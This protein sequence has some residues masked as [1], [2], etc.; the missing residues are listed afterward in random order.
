MKSIK[1]ILIYVLLFN[2]CD[3]N[4][5][6]S[7]SET[8]S[9]GEAITFN[10]GDEPPFNSANAYDYTG[11]VH[12]DI[13]NSYYDLSY[14]PSSLDSIV[15]LVT[16]EMGKHD[17][18][19]ALPNYNYHQFSTA[20]IDSIIHYPETLLQHSFDEMPLTLGAKDSLETF[21]E[22]LFVKVRAEED[23]SE[24]YDF[25]VDFETSLIDS[26]YHTSEDKEFILTVTSIARYS[27]YNKDKKPDPNTDPDWDW[28]TT[29]IV[30]SINGAG[31][32]IP[33]SI[34]MALKAGIG[35]H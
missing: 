34:A 21:V 18:Y 28:L 32:S 5:L 8:P 26:P 11:H 12:S 3:S 14:L 16:T 25:I 1:L 13:F 17:Y 33:E 29:C 31:Y 35:N 30:G 20:Y 6:I 2:A 4:D 10:K 24:I 23:Y 7:E 27:I 9:K 19:K 22:D 15:A